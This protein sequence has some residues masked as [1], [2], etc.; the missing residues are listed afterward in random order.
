[1]V[2]PADVLDFAT[3]FAMQTL[4]GNPVSAAAGAAVL[5]AIKREGLV[6]NAR[7]VGAHLAG[8]LEALMTSRPEIGSVRGRGLAIGVELVEDRATRAPAKALAAKTVYRA[9]ELGLVVYY[10][11]LESN[12]LELTPPLILTKAEAD[13]AVAILGQAIADAASGK[14]SDAAIK[15]FAGW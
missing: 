4:H 15:A 12:V 10:V 1:M 13:K 6:E 5:D 2:G 14:V 9:F 11:G 8:R 3:A 7:V